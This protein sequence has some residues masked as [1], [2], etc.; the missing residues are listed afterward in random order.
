MEGA[1]HRMSPLAEMYAGG[2]KPFRRNFPGRDLSQLHFRYS[3]TSSLRAPLFV[4]ALK[5]ARF[6]G[7]TRPTPPLPF[8]TS[9]SCTAIRRLFLQVLADPLKALPAIG[10]LAPTTFLRRLS[11]YV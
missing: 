1:H 4:F 2:C 5:R 10:K 3:P 11:L 9:Y 7:R 8:E 6:H